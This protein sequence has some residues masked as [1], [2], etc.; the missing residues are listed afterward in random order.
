[1]MCTI[2]GNTFFSF[3]KNT[4]IRDLGASCHIT[5]NDN[6][7]YDVI[8]ID[9][10]IQ[11]SFDIM[12]AM[13]KCKL[14]VTVRQVNGEEQVHTLWPVKFCPLAGANLFSLTCKLSWGNKISS[15]E[16]NNIIMNTPS[17]DIILDRQIKI[18]D[19][20]VAR[21]YFL[22]ASIDDRAPTHT[23]FSTQKQNKLF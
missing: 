17:G 10:W 19:R 14:R 2:D 15:D 23:G 20:W 1:M 22:Q 8:D 13:K 16:V 7:M 3:T 6:G 4:L 11:G 21:V 5:N 12:P 18:H 9:E